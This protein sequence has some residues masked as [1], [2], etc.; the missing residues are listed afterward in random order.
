MAVLETRVSA[1][2]LDMIVA[3]ALKDNVV[4]LPPGRGQPYSLLLKRGDSTKTFQNRGIP[5]FYC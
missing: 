2:A 5:R 1:R 4:S 3:I